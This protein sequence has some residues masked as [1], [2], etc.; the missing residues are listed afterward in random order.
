MHQTVCTVQLTV[1]VIAYKF[2]CTSGNGNKIFN[3]KLYVQMANKSRS[4]RSETITNIC[5]LPDPHRFSF[6]TTFNER[7]VKALRFKINLPFT[8]CCTIMLCC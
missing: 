2:A 5:L 1:K 6:P 7:E 8:T 3:L 4:P